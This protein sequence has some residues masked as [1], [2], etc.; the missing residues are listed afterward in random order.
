MF[1]RNCWPF[2]ARVTLVNTAEPNAGVEQV[3]IPL[4][5]KETFA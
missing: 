1:V 4:V 2:S 5:A 3:K